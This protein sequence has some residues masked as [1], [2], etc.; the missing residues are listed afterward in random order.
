M[1]RRL[2]QPVNILVIIGLVFG[3]TFCIFTPSKGERG[4]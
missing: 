4:Q 2:L 3:I 1:T